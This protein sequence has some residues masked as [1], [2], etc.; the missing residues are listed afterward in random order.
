MKNKCVRVRLVVQE[1]RVTA[2][3]QTRSARGTLAYRGKVVRLL[4]NQETKTIKGALGAA[5]TELLDG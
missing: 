4:D 1:G 5:I 2:H 3:A